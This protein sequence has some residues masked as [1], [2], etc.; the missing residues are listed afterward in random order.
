MR[1][2]VCV[3][4]CLCVEQQKLFSNKI[5][6]CTQVFCMVIWAFDK[7]KYKHI[8]GEW[9]GKQQQQ[10]QQQQKY[11]QAYILLIKLSKTN[12]S[13]FCMHIKYNNCGRIQYSKT[14]VY[15]TRML[16]F[17]CLYTWFDYYYSHTKYFWSG[18]LFF[19]AVSWS[20]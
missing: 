19:E 6:T 8:P 10:Q 3:H 18:I 4:V 20:Y 5:R 9:M 13:Q 16:N 2:R 1:E 11:G 12:F 7:Y 14:Y 17:F 15:W